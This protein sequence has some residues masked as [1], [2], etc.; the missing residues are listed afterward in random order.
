VRHLVWQGP[1][2]VEWQE[3][4]DPA[5]GPSDAVVRP[6]AV[7]RCD[8]DPVMAAFGIYPGPFP[9]GHEVAGEVVAVGEDVR[10]HKSGDRVIVPFQVSCG[11]CEAC[12]HQRFTACKNHQ[13]HIGAA[14]GFG[15]AGG[16]HGGA[17]AD[18]L[19]VPEADH[20]LHPAPTELGP[21]V[22]CLLTDNFLDGYRAVALPLADAPDAEVLVVG[23]AAASTGLYAV[24]WALAL[25]ARKVRY[26]DTDA[27]RCEQAET[28]GATTQLHEGPWPKGFERALVTLDNTADPDGH[29]CTIRSTEDYGIC[30]PIAVGFSPTTPV[31]L[32]SMYTRGVTVRL[33]RADSR[34]YLADVVDHVARGNIDPLSVK[35]NVVGFEQAKQAWLEEPQT[36]LIVTRDASDA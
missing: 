16:D 9:V 3:T 7:A 13:A 24:L 27:G 1:G 11:D 14:F 31:P 36:K 6:L 23:G 18:L 19:L 2:H 20:L 28:M 17:V 10:R 33:G 35:T 12:G 25:G 4:P 22:L 26:V 8:L 21:T 30:T 32:L 15:P 5:P 34:R 29:Q